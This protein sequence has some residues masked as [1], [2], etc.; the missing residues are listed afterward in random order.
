VKFK[1]GQKINFE[2]RI[3]RRKSIG[4]FVAD[5]SIWDG[6]GKAEFGPGPG[7]E[8]WGEFGGGE[9]SALS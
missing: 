6:I 7:A 5:L 4:K 9:S 1:I 2:G 3:R 8:P